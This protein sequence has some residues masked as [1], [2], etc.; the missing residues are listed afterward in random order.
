MLENNKITIPDNSLWQYL[1]KEHLIEHTD[2]K[3]TDEEWSEF[4]RQFND[5]FADQCSELGRD[6]LSIYIDQREK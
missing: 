1:E 2:I 5:V 3:L 6:L 4:C